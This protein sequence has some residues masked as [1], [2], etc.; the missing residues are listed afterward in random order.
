[1]RQE[2]TFA[3]SFWMKPTNEERLGTDADRQKLTY[4]YCFALS[5]AYV[6]KLG[7]KIKLYGDKTS[8]EFL[9]DIPYD[10]VIEIKC[11]SDANEMFW[12][13]SKFYA[14][15]EMSI[16]EALIDGDIFLKHQDILEPILNDTGDVMVQ[17]LES[18]QMILSP[19]YTKCREYLK[20]FELGDIF[21]PQKLMP[22]CNTGLLLFNS[23]ALKEKYISEYFRI[24]EL[25]NASGKV[26]PKDL[27][28]D[29]LLEQLM[30]N[31]LCIHD[32]YKLSTLFDTSEGPFLKKNDYKY[33]HLISDKK[34]L[35]QPLVKLWLKDINPELHEKLN[36]YSETLL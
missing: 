28:P 2:L 27:C 22:I 16:N 29:I 4:L 36:N 9:K 5:A 25:I 14:L 35:M 3:H 30:L 19:G 8:L 18:G 21:K 26:M 20:D 6:K 11:P 17:S 24:M 23:E 32:G 31:Q 10:E 1:M 33:V 34:F 15:Q 7:Y 13:Q 12:A